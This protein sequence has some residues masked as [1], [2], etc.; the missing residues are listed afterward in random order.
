LFWR[1][2][3]RDV[4]LREV[5]QEGEVDVRLGQVDI[6]QTDLFTQRFQCG[7]LGDEPQLNGRLV[8][9]PTLSLGMARLLQLLLVE[10][11]LSQ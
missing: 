3:D 4:L 2:R 9:S 7:L 10:Q 1:I 6:L 8:Q 11:S 5:F